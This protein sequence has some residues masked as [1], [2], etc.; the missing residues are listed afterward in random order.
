M[1]SI[2]NLS[3]NELQALL[4]KT[5]SENL[6]MVLRKSKNSFSW[7]NPVHKA[8]PLLSLEEANEYFHRER[9]E[10]T[11]GDVIKIVQVANW[12]TSQGEIVITKVVKV[13]EKK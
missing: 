12:T 3:G 7:Y 6:H 2:N 9:Q 5:P 8:N 4:F 11:S 1:V 10:F 13:F